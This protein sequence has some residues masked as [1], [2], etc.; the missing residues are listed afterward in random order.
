[1]K[2]KIL[3]A[4]L[5]SM[6]YAFFSCSD[7][8]K[9]EFPDGVT[10]VKMI[11]KQV[12]VRLTE[13]QKDYVKANNE[14]AFNLFKQTNGQKGSRIISPLGV[15]YMLG[16][17][18]AGA[19]GSTAT[20]IQE[21]MGIQD[22]DKTSVNNYF[23]S[24]YTNL[25]KVDPN[26][27]LNIA[28]AL[29]VDKSIKILPSFEKNMTT[30]YGAVVQQLDF[31]S[32]S[33]I[34][35]INKWC[36]KQSK[37]E[38]DRI[39]DETDSNALACLLNAVFFKASWTDKFN[40]DDT[41]DEPFTREDGTTASL[42]MMNRHAKVLYSKASNYSA[43]CL[44][45]SSG[46]F[47]MYVLLPDEGVSVDDVVSSLNTQGWQKQKD[48]MTNMV[49]DVYVDEDG[50][51]FTTE[52]GRYIYIK[53]PRFTTA[54]NADVT[55]PLQNLGI[56]KAFTEKAEFPFIAE[57][58]LP[59]AAVRQ[60]TRIVVDEEGTKTAAVAASDIVTEAFTA[61]LT[62]Y[63]NRPFLYLIQENT[64]GIILFAG[65]YMGD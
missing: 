9:E 1:M 27:E 34:A 25:P 16:M 12:P 36:E 31:A 49:E 42:P 8:D 2:N 29:F 44:P 7:N 32:P 56:R 57:Q 54:F 47:N 28:N 50:Q 14:F 24:L 26:V 5:V 40:S 63:A 64:S 19:D 21:V 3:V 15:A 23:S 55:I 62:F 39:M 59:L 17:L 61:P 13:E 10:Y 6:A 22:A 18:N 43:I 65:T 53:I 33:A 48:Q 37:G 35:T 60:L 30:S 51:E 4:T 46:A 45:Y 41:R 11:P 20:E 58:K 38:V 52:I